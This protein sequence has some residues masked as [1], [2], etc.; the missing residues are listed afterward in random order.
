MAAPAVD[1]RILARAHANFVENDRLLARLSPR[2]AIEEGDGLVLVSTGFPTSQL[3]YAITTYLP[4]DPEGALRRVRQFFAQAGVTWRLWAWSDV[5]DALA[6]IAEAEGFSPRPPEPGMLLSPLPPGPPPPPPDL[7]VQPVRDAG[8]LRTFNDTFAASFDLPRDGVELVF[9]PDLLEVPDATLLL[10]WADGTP[11]TM[12][13]G[14]TSHRIAGI[15]AIGTLPAYR[16]RGFGT[17]MTWRA[18]LDDRQ[19]CLA[20]YLTASSIGFPIYAG[21]GFQHVVDYR[22]WAG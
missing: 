18:A 1:P 22:R 20:A 21:M 3:N 5:G 8:S 16:R 4:A 13:L 10:G 6:P 7:S 11:A 2:G 14:F 9:T 19:D 12:A 15:F 17:A